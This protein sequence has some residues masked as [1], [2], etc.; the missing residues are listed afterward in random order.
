MEVLK[1]NKAAIKPKTFEKPKTENK[2][3]SSL[4]DKPKKKFVPKKGTPKVQIVEKVQYKN[5]KNKKS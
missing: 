1:E 4:S 5:G 3:A 2:P